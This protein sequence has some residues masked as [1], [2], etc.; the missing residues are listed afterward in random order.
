MYDTNRFWF[1]T[2][3]SSRSFRPLYHIIINNR[4]SLPFS[5][6]WPG[7]H[8]Y[9]P[10]CF[11]GL[12]WLYT[13]LLLFC[14]FITLSLY[15]IVLLLYF[16]IFRGNGDC[17]IVWN[18]IHYW[19]QF[20]L[21]PYFI[22][23]SENIILHYL[24]KCWEYLLVFSHWVS[25][26]THYVNKHCGCFLKTSLEEAGMRVCIYIHTYVYYNVHVQST[27]SI[28]TSVVTLC[29]TERAILKQVY[30]IVSAVSKVVNRKEMI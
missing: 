25:H 29:L 26:S 22:D 7:E 12:T 13:L 3:P 18:K 23:V 20:I 17:K 1:V 9:T 15:C 16:N 14:S 19:L 21:H 5:L 30:F 27:G 10:M 4:I 28:G 8:T 2:T 24:L 6:L 11:C